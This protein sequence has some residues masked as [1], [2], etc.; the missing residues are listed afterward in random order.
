MVRTEQWSSIV[1]AIELFSKRVSKTFFKIL[2]DFV[3]YNLFKWTY[4]EE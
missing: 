4:S 2:S 3:T 1:R